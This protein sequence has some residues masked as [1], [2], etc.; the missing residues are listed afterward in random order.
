MPRSLLDLPAEVRNLIY[1]FT[2]VKDESIDLWPAS[3]HCVNGFLEEGAGPRDHGGDMGIF[4]QVMRVMRRGLQVNLLRTC[5]S[6][7]SEA[8]PILYGRNEFRF[9]MEDCWVPL[10]TF[11]ITIGERNRAF[12][13]SLSVF[14]PIESLFYE[15]RSHMTK[16]P[17]FECWADLMHIDL[18]AGHVAM[19]V[20][21]AVQAC[22][23][24]WMEEKTLK[25][26]YLVAPRGI[27]LDRD[28]FQIGLFEE[29]KPLMEAKDELSL[30]I[31]LVMYQ[32][33]RLGEDGGH[34]REMVDAM[35]QV[36]EELGWETLILFNENDKYQVAVFEPTG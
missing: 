31:K 2:L 21:E 23:T 18:P 11:L 6:I 30:A 34:G 27:H 4:G 22:C 32:N 29:F 12:I 26:L 7:S 16:V 14:V 28:A 20:T 15:E 5:K 1:H 8:T 24:M 9:T 33:A 36:E 17:L 35:I 3:R 19:S 10:H 25:T 13:R